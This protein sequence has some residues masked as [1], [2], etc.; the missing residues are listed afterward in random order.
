MGQISQFYPWKKITTSTV[1]IALRPGDYEVLKQLP[2]DR[3]GLVTDLRLKEQCGALAALR[4]VDEAIIAEVARRSGELLGEDMPPSEVRER[5]KP[6]VGRGGVMRI[7]Y[8]PTVTPSA[9]EATYFPRSYLRVFT[10]LH[11]DELIDAIATRFPVNVATLIASMVYVEEVQGASQHAITLLA[12]GR[13]QPR[14]ELAVGHYLWV[15][16]GRH[17]GFPY[18]TAEVLLF[19]PGE[20]AVNA[21]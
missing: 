7:N 15:L 20:A 9:F 14:C 1:T 6:I 16:S 2:S 13:A 18:P 17:F 21:E 3:P 5:Y 8:R 11:Q 10:G 4:Q 19:G 12:T